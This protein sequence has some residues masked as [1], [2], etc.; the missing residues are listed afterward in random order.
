M[1]FE[2]KDTTSPPVLRTFARKGAFPEE[3]VDFYVPMLE[4]HGSVKAGV[5]LDMEHDMNKGY[6]FMFRIAHAVRWIQCVC[7]VELGYLGG[8]LS[9]NDN[10]GL[11]FYGQRIPQKIGTAETSSNATDKDERTSDDN[12]SALASVL[13]SLR[14]R[15][16][17]NQS[18]ILHLSNAS[19]TSRCSIKTD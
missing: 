5:S 19:A 2:N 7:D 3:D 9:L 16:A 12:H 11:G 10:M 6:E 15:H 14:K 1:I 18:R 17:S 13:S 8:A 4:Q